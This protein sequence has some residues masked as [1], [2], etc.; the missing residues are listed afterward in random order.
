MRFN[1]QAFCVAIALTLVGVGCSHD[2]EVRN[3]RQYKVAYHQALP[4]SLAIGIDYKGD[5]EE[6]RRLVAGVADALYKYNANSQFPYV[7][8]AFRQVDVI[9]E[10][11]VTPDYSGSVW[12][13]FITFPGF[14]IF[15]PSWNG[16]VYSADY[17]FDITL[18]NGLDHNQIEAF[19]VPVRLNLRHADGGRTWTE[20]WIPF[21]PFSPLHGLYNITYD[22]D[23]T[24]LVVD[25][26]IPDV[27]DYVA[28][29]IASRV[30][31]AG[32]GMK[33]VNP[34]KKTG[35]SFD[36]PT[37]PSLLRTGNTPAPKPGVA[38]APPK[39]TVPGAVVGGAVV[40]GAATTGTG[41]AAVAALPPAEGAGETYALVIGINDYTSL[42]PLSTPVND[43][44]AVA[45]VLRKR[46][47]CKVMSLE[48]PTRAEIFDALATCRTTL[49]PDSRLILYYA[50]HGWNDEKAKEGYWLPVDAEEGNKANWIPHSSITA[51]LCAIPAKQILVISDSCYAGVMTRGLAFSDKPTDKK[52]RVA[53]LSG[54][55]EPVADSGANAG[56]SVFAAALLDTL[57]N[58]NGQLSG[59]ALWKTVKDRVKN[60]SD[61]TPQ[62]SP[63][64]KAGHEDGDFF[65]DAA[66]RPVAP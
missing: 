65:F 36:S 3:L 57:Q 61:Q 39:T 37:Q 42:T 31:A 2:L 22:G 15:A 62:F 4:K 51:E 12:N 19:K 9:A 66:A 56:H 49:A 23:T 30:A 54:G 27:G 63:M 18:F 52:V 46:F 20:I 8:S 26:V 32:V 44:R 21:A 41:K 48:N 45:D 47:G 40:G 14:L 55:N 34:G 24:E 5:D 38:T 58:S 6:C 1:W 16:C 13:F 53:L 25:K 7:V 11:K 33:P 10:V 50:G 60:S 43:S 35:P 59:N 64:F 28:G 17:D 29:K